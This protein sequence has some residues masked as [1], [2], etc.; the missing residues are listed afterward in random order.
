[1]TEED[2]ELHMLS[3]T[4]YMVLLP[5]LSEDKVTTVDVETLEPSWLRETEDITVSIQVTGTVKSK[6]T[7]SEDV[8]LTNKLKPFTTEEDG[9]ASE[10]TEEDTEPHKVSVTELLVP[11]PM[12]SEDKVT[13]VDVET[14][15]L[16]SLRKTEDIM[17][18]IH[19]IGDV[20]FHV[21]VVEL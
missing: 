18:S 13:T 11:P 5:M 4:E 7:T 9:C 6:L 17:E 2:T 1:L 16:S 8:G 20:L 21:C 3:V 10:L 15:E 19:L 14:P 12:P